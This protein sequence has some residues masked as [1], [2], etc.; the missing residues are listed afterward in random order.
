[1]NRPESKERDAYLEARSYEREAR[2]K[3]KRGE[4]GAAIEQ[5]KRYA[6]VKERKGRYFFSIYGYCNLARICDKCQQW[7]EAAEFFV[8]ASKHTEKIGEYSLWVL[9]MNLACQMFEEMGNY[10]ACKSCYETLGNFF[11]NVN[12]FFGSADAYEHAA[13][14]MVLSGKDISDYE[15]PLKA[16][17]ENYE[18]WK[19]KGEMDDAEWSLKRIATYRTYQNKPFFKKESDA[20]ETFIKD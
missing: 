6:K 3:E 11:D 14:I 8:V 13:E 4:Y 17:K 2:Q 10:D 16:W 12:N 1:M 19:E 15:A 20:Q 18:Y 9:L 5:W 7:K